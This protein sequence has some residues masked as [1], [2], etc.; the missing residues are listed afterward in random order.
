MR[1]PEHPMT[2]WTRACA[3]ATL[4]GAV[5]SA[6]AQ[7]QRDPTEGGIYYTVAGMDRVVVRSNLAFK[8]VASL[9]GSPGPVDLKLD[10]YIPPDLA[11]GA[12]SP[13]MVF[14]H[15]GNAPG[16]PPLKGLDIF[17][18]WGR[19]A[20][21]S[22]LVGITFNHRMSTRDNVDEAASD[23]VDL[24]AYV[25]RN[26]AEL[27]ADPDRLCV[28]FFSAGGPL[29]SVLLRDPQPFVRCVVLYY[30][31]LDLEHLTLKTPFRD[32]YPQ[33]HADSLRDY[34]PALALTKH[35]GEL[36]PILLARGGRDAIPYLN[37]SIA[38]FVSAAMQNNVRLDFYIHPMGQHGFDY[39][40]RDERTREII[41]E[42]LA[43]VTRH[44]R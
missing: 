13:A 3:L 23:L 17:R 30:P 18:T 31:Y 6:G 27:R 10:A 12:R 26:A 40:N 34:S 8:T 44:T 25:R 20:A 39:A 41:A 9:N 29:S 43:F 14:V 19:V 38:R 7:A 35:S 32:P 2:R 28:M 42:T 16:A 4:A 24:L 1:E 37:A 33:A 36:P 5:S 21:A 11:P 22:G 15:G